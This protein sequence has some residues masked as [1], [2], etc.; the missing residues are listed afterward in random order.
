MGR[1]NKLMAIIIDGMAP[2][3]PTCNRNST[4]LSIFSKLGYVILLNMV[5]I[6]NADKFPPVMD[7]KKIEQKYLIFFCEE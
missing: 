1:V 3:I 6:I 5:K 4:I 7:V 2:I